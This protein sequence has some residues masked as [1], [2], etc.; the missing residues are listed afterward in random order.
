MSDMAILFRQLSHNQPA[1]APSNATIRSSEN[2]NPTSHHRLCA[3]VAMP[4]AKKPVTAVA[5]STSHRVSL[6]APC[7]TKMSTDATVAPLP[8]APKMGPGD[9]HVA[10][11]TG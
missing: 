2:T 1:I 11:F 9:F 7:R 6:S 8:T 5:M 3:Q 4:V 10:L